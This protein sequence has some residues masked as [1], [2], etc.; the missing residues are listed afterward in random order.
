MVSMFETAVRIECSS[1]AIALERATARGDAPILGRQ[2]GVTALERA[3]IQFVR[4]R[5]AM[6][7]P[8]TPVFVG[9]VRSV[10]TRGLVSQDFVRKFLRKNEATVR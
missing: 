5:P 3:S 10:S 7:K 6:M 2:E 4:S 1:A 8:R 9:M